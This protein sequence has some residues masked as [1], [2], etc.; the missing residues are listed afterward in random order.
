LCCGKKIQSHQQMFLLAIWN[1]TGGNIIKNIRIDVYKIKIVL[2][3][4]LINK[5]LK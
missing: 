5:K 2:F 3:K 4:N 1:G